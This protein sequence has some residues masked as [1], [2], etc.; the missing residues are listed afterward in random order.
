MIRAEAEED[1]LALCRNA[2][3]GDALL[4]GPDP[5]TGH[6]EAKSLGAR[7]SI[8]GADRDDELGDDFARGGERG[9]CFDD[10]PDDLSLG[11]IS[12]SGHGEQ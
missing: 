5:A 7:L 3:V 8:A 4:E 12:E 10:S 9:V 11:C 2:E 1:L 6:D